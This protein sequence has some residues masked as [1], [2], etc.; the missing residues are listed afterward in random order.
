MEMRACDACRGLGRMMEAGR[1]VPCGECRGTGELLS[2]MKVQ[3]H[4]I[5]AVLFGDDNLVL[6]GMCIPCGEMVAM[7]DEG[8]DHVGH[9]GDRPFKGQKKKK[10]RK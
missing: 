2:H 10:R 1:V 9:P 6:V 5:E 4:R 3:S 8:I 7:C